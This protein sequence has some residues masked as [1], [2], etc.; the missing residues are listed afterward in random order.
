[1]EIYK[2][3][4]LEIV[5]LLFRTYPWLRIK[6]AAE[7]NTK[8]IVEIS[9]II[10]LFVRF[11]II[12]VYL[13][14][15]LKKSSINTMGA[16]WVN[17]SGGR[18]TLDGI[19]PVMGAK[20]AVLKA[21]AASVLF[22]NEMVIENM[23]FIE[24]VFKMNEI[25]SGLG[26]KVES[27]GERSFVFKI[28]KEV[29]GDLNDELAKTLRASIVLS[30][31]VL[32]R[33]GHVSFPHPGGCVIG[34]R[35]IDIFLDGFAKMGAKLKTKESSYV[36]ECPRLK[37]AEIFF[38]AQS[39]TATETFMMAGVL[40][41]GTTVLKNCACEPE[42]SSLADFLN[43]CGADIKGAGTHNIIVRGTGFLKKGIYRT[44]PDRLEAGSFLIIGALCGKNL[45]IINCEPGHLEAVINLLKEAGV[46]IRTGGN[47]IS[48]KAPV[49]LKA[50]NL[51]THEYPGFPTDLQALFTVL[52]TQ[53]EGK[54][55]VFETVF[56]GRLDYI[57]DLKRMGADAVICDQHR[58]IIN[59][60]VKLSGR[61]MDGPDLRAGLAFLVAGLVADGESVIN[62]AYNIDRGYEKIEERLA[63]VGADIKRI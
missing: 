46:K 52:L 29:G 4:V 1:V 11:S 23:P 24:D 35:P 3:P 59:G 44:I 10:L 8:T 41:S 16:F 26:V 42:I 2:P 57:N 14:K 28:P 15:S 54:S 48:V 31:P 51:K 18:K 5:K 62:N 61:T 40:A 49:S 17:G 63:V 27:M 12:Y 20:N 56:E 60:P 7:I 9:S 6:T 53:A 34:K 36:L 19:L 45:K 33:N 13:Q 30:G 25:L 39:M 38:K 55:L 50:V 32:A 43:S 22:K 21:Q 58:A 37:G 47:F